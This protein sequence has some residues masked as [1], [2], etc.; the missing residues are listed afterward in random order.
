MS[1]CVRVY[2][3]VRACVCVCVCVCMCVCACACMCACV[4]QIQDCYECALTS[5]QR[6]VHRCMKETKQTGPCPQD[7]QVCD[8]IVDISSLKHHFSPLLDIF[9]CCP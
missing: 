1:V 7:R 8:A 9:A 5:R 6:H 2:M 3:C 4:Y